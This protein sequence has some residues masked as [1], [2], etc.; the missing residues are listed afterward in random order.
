MDRAHHAPPEM[1]L[2]PA[3]P[4]ERNGKRRM[5]PETVLIPV[6]TSPC[7]AVVPAFV[8]AAAS[9]GHGCHRVLRMSSGVAIT[10]FRRCVQSIERRSQA[11]SV[12]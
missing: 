3:R 11:H 8:R 2:F 9:S 6:M 7:A 4:V 1:S 12:P 5:K 10:H